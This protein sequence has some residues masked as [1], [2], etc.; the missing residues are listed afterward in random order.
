MRQ[1]IG[2]LLCIVGACLIVLRGD[3]K[4]L[5]NLSFVQGDLL[6][7]VA[8]CSTACTP[9]CCAGAGRPSAELSDRHLF[10]ARQPFT[11]LPGGAGGR[12]PFC[13]EPHIVRASCTSPSSL[14]LRPIS[15]GT[16]GGRS[17]P[18]RAGLFINLIRYS[19]LCCRSASWRVDPG[20]S[21]R[22]HESD[23][24]RDG[25]VLPCQGLMAPYKSLRSS[26]GDPRILSGQAPGPRTS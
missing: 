20:L 15:A 16:R 10:L 24:H 5:L 26:P 19:P 9:R 7:I 22:R 17:G 12:R 11:G 25:D 1:M 13:T 21:H 4:T 3:L 6:M 8:W 14:P 23:L 2:V 18:N